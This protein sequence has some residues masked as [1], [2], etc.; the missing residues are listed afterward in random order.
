MCGWRKKNESITSSTKPRFLEN[1]LEDEHL[2]ASN[3]SLYIMNKSS[4]PVSKIVG[5]SVQNETMEVTSVNNIYNNVT[6]RDLVDIGGKHSLKAEGN[7]LDTIPEG[8]SSQNQYITN[9]DV[10][11]NDD[12]RENSPIYSEIGKIVEQT[13]EEI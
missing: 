1:N 3:Q 9:D 10:R 12:I 2:E 6:H 7:V 11:Q 8:N 4:S 13:W 5:E